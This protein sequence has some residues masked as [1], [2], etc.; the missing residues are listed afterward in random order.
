MTIY[1]Y[2]RQVNILGTFI[3]REVTF[4]LRERFEHPN[5]EEMPKKIEEITGTCKLY[6]KAK[7]CI[8]C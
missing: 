8:K 2:T 4:S 7:R 6:V 5:F 3:F 1:D